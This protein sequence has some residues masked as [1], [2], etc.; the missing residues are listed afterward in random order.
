[1]LAVGGEK[2]VSLEVLRRTAPVEIR[3]VDDRFVGATAEHRDH[4]GQVAVA[5]VVLAAVRRV[6]PVRVRC[7]HHVGRV[8]IGAV[9][10]LGQPEG[11]DLP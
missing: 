5:D 7:Q 1:M 11:E 3:T 6:R 8:D 10:L 9:V 4:A 2:E